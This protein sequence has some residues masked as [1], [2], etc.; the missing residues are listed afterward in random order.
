MPRDNILVVTISCLTSISLNSF[1]SFSAVYLTLLLTM[2]GL[3]V[4][5]TVLVL[6]FHHKADKYSD[7]IGRRV[8]HDVHNSKLYR[9]CKDNSRSNNNR[10]KTTSLTKNGVKPSSERLLQDSFEIE[11]SDGQQSSEDNRSC[12]LKLHWKCAQW[13]RQR[14]SKPL[15]IEFAAKLDRIMFFVVTILTIMST[16]ISMV[17]LIYW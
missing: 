7:Y 5:S 9:I 14:K 17:L 3:S 16:V 15:G 13:R 4:A 1:L 2:S 11:D 10:R 12:C 6:Y 8:K